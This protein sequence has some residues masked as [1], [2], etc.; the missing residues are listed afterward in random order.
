MKLLFQLPPKTKQMLRLD[1]GETIHYCVPY[2]ISLKGTYTMDSYVVVTNVRIFVIENQEIC[3]QY[4]L[5]E[6]EN[7]KC[8]S[9]VGNGILV[10][11][12][13]K[14]KD[15]DIILARFTM[16]HIVRQSYVAKGASIFIEG[17]TKEIQ[18][19]ELEKTCPKCGRP[20]PGT[21]TCPK[22][23]DRMMTWKRFWELCSPYKKRL[24]A[25]SCIMMA[26][27]VLNLLLPDVQKRFIDGSL[28][29]K[30]GTTK[31]ILQ[32][33]GIT[34]ILTISIILLN[35]WKNWLCVS[36][37][38]KMSM[39]IRKKLYHKVQM[40]TISF[41]QDKRPGEL[42]NRIVSDTGRI[43]SFME[44]AFGGMFSMIITMVG[45]IGFMITMNW[46]LTVLT[47]VFM[48]IVLII[49][50]LWQKK[51]RSMYRM[52]W[53]K[54]DKLNSGLQD[55]ISGM[56]VV[57]S[58]GKEKEEAD[59][60]NTLNKEFAQV[61]KT[62]EVFWASFFPIM[63]F[64]MGLGVYFVT[65]LGGVDVLNGALT[66]GELVQFISYTGILYGPL[67]WMTH[68]PRM[69][70]NML[71]SLERVYDVLDEQPSIVD[72][73][74]AKIIDIKG[75]VEF[76]NVSFGYKSYEPVLEKINLKVK[77]GEMIG[78]VGASGTGKSTLINLIMHLYEVDDGE[79]LI[80]GTNINQ[81]KVDNY[82][83]QI[84][85]VLQET[86]L[87]SGTILNNLRFARPDATYE[88]IIM[89]AKMA[90]AHDFICKTPDGYNT[91]VGEHGHNLSGGERQRLAIARAI[92]NNPKLLI[93]DEATSS[94]DTESEYLIQKAL[95]RL[96]NGRT[97]FA[98][99]HRLSTLKDADRLV[100][101][102]GHNIAEVG[103]HNELMEKKGIY[104]GLVT[105]QLE[106]Q[107]VK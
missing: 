59:K 101:I 81:L 44:E 3:V 88:E 42:M 76:K 11:Q 100:V 20:L 60:F 8:E 36:L 15:V 26:A 2:D 96:T 65:F 46:Q 28:S 39:D 52:Q 17:G 24:L 91:Y 43:R 89:A 23:D 72:H 49:T 94:L 84:G 47:V 12:E 41:I 71:T 93:L 50:R 27:A 31:D 51:I 73:K 62:N 45:V 106:M 64:I 90:N 78:L 34:F 79:I 6:L 102:D 13:K 19:A 40:L 32:F 98:I 33:I 4:R 18:S 21:R 82:H 5:A 105:A 37:G 83:A 29:T 97:T 87:F 22:C 63:T 10:V 38:S 57:K 68:L 54:F 30:T 92:L 103:T 58:F 85:V 16:K 9:Q 74:D 75:D 35:V 80:D 67:G 104:Y 53:F 77:K 55:V 86:F 69:I 95:E 66:K 1:G 70:T 14:Q 25:V 48:P 107:S 7:I 61:Q 56:R 99:A